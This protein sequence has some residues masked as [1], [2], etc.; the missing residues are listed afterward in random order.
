MPVL[1]LNRSQGII[2]KNI[3]I[4]DCPASVRAKK[5]QWT[6]KLVIIPTMTMCI[7]RYHAVV[8]V[9]SYN[10]YQNPFLLSYQRYSLQYCKTYR[11]PYH[12]ILYQQQ[13]YLIFRKGGFVD[14]EVEGGPVNLTMIRKILFYN[15]LYGWEYIIKYTKDNWT[16][17]QQ[18]HGIM[19]HHQLEVM[20]K[21]IWM[22]QN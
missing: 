21:Y 3:S 11:S 6:Q 13:Q 10:T 22:L 7:T 5:H 18:L 9:V 1:K 2:L 20:I 14:G 8:M 4:V 17:H 19:L 12:A 16:Q 15:T